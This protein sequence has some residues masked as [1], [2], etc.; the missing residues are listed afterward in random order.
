[1]PN[2][3][4][5]DATA[6]GG[7]QLSGSI[8]LGEPVLRGGNTIVPVILSVSPDSMTPQAMALSVHFETRGAIGNVTARR[9]GVTRDIAAVF[10]IS[11]QS[12]NDLAYLVS[13]DPRGLDLG[14]SRSA[15]VAEIEL[16]TAPA[17]ATM[18]ISATRTM[19]TDQGGTIK[20][21]V[22]N[23]KLSVKGIAIGNGAS[24]RPLNPNH[25][26]N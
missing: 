15:V 8:V 2:Q 14:P 6:G 3:R 19:L 23:K 26:L 1:L 18:T 7:L 24:P 20:A 9:A 10:E 17:R 22:G 5:V 16:A 13:Y 12:G 11:M 21:T 25:R 4:S